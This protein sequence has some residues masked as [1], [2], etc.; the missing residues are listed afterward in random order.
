MKLHFLGGADEIGASCTL[1]EI[2]GHRILVDAGLRMGARPGSQLPHFARLDE[3]GPPE[4]VLITHAHTDHTG[5]LPVLCTSLPADVKIYATAPTK[6]LVEVLWADAAK[7]MERE[8]ELPLYPRAAAEAALG[9]MTSV[10]WL[11]TLP[12]CDG[13][14]HATWI[15]AGHILGAAQIFIEGQRESVLFTGDVSL[16]PQLTIPGLV[17]PQ[18][19]PDVL[20]MESTYGN[21][22]H[23]DRAQQETGLAL[24]VAEVIAAGGKVLI[25]AF[26]IGR[27]QEVIL[28]LVRAMR[29]KQISEFPIWVDGMV[30]VVNT[31][32]ADHGDLLA[33]PVRHR[34]ERGKDIFYGDQAQ[35]V[36]SPAERQ[37]VL[38]GPPCCIV[39]SS[40]MLI[41]GASSHYA[42]H[43]VDDPAN[44]I[45]ITGY[46][47]EEAPGRALLNLMQTPADQK[48][49]LTLNGETR[50]V[51]CQVEPYSLSAHADRDELAGL[52]QRLRPRT[53]FLVHGDASARTALATRVDLYLPEGVQLP[54]NSGVYEVPPFVSKR[55]PGYGR[56]PRQSGLARGRALSPEAL[57]E[58]SAHIRD[59]SLRGPWR[60]QALAEL[61]LGSRPSDLTELATFQTWLDTDNGYFTPDRQRPYLYHPRN[62][63][64]EPV[65]SGRMEMNAAR[66]LIQETFPATTGLY[67][68]STH[69]AQGVFE[70][71]FFF[72][73]RART[74]HGETLA[75]LETETGWTFRLRDTPHQEQLGM[76][77]TAVLPDGTRATTAPAVHMSRKAVVIRVQVPSELAD[78]W[79][80]E[81]ASA[82][83][84]FVATTGFTLELERVAPTLSQP[85]VLPRE[86]GTPWEINQAFQAIRQAFVDQPH[87]PLKVGVRNGIIEVSFVSP[88]VGARYQDLLDKL[89]D[90]LHWGIQIR[91]YANHQVI[92]QAAEMLTPAAC[93]P[94]G[95]IQIHVDD[96]RVVV[97]VTCLPPDSETLAEAFTAETG[98]TI[99]WQEPR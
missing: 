61:W 15:P 11:T 83:K 67:R 75:R 90:T 4:A 16:A 60:V 48:R 29:R 51:A 76:A 56:R 74:Q 95:R 49:S 31:I 10:P 97:P 21:R 14:L 68:C 1:L 47:D 53:C 46:Q 62:P 96:E 37:T 44:L 77:A 36:S 73:D 24:R 12:L 32:Y 19:R 20:V 27:A 35:P 17:L 23:A 69:Q 45:A 39:A 55:Q 54:D 5:T 88:T 26:A 93:G 13:A 66:A 57:V 87:Q 65:S 81:A 28:L 3:A 84:A 43:L 78:T 33:P 82:A 41:G 9:R 91:A 70:L 94:H 59:K 50:N 2:E 99:T 8:G 52:V 80:E 34:T 58:I 40:G 6:S 25:P 79:P 85:L 42:A 38:D 7:L 89:S 64:E 18:C 22:Q 92:T 30:R 63:E 72:P 86:T 71:A 98:F